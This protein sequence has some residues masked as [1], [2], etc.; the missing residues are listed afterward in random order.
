MS[1]ALAEIARN[2]ERAKLLRRIHCLEGDFLLVPTLEKAY[3]LAKLWTAYARMS[4]GHP[5]WPNRAQAC[6]RVARFHEWRRGDDLEWLAR[7]HAG[8]LVVETGDGFVVNGRIFDPLLQ[9]QVARQKQGPFS[10]SV[11]R[12]R[13]RMEV[14]RVTCRDC[15]RLD[16]ACGTVRCNSRVDEELA[17]RRELLRRGEAL[18]KGD[19]P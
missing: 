11:F 2:E 9:D 18:L 3:E 17:E 14:R 16:A 6:E 1:D 10:W 19:E 8:G 5:G 15:P 12:V 13:V 7:F 4:S